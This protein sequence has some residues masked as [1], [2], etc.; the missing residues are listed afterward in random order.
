MIS[1]IW[2]NKKGLFEKSPFLKYILV[3]H[4]KFAV[5]KQDRSGDQKNIAKDI[6]API[7]FFA[8]CHI[9]FDIA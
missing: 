4:K 2:A 8:L 6:P 1:W 7:V 9:P 5:N 3:L